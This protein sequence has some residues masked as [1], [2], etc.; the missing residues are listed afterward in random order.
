MNADV[1]LGVKHLSLSA[2]LEGLRKIKGVGNGREK[3]VMVE[4]KSMNFV[5]WQSW[6]K[7]TIWPPFSTAMV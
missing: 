3:K 6:C 5:A 7:E 1:L 4:N 2:R